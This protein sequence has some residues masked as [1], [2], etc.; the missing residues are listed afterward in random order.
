MWCSRWCS[1][2]E[3]GREGGIGIG[4]DSLVN[5]IDIRR[6][7]KEDELGKGDR[8]HYQ[9][10]MSS[11]NTNNT[12]QENKEAKTRKEGGLFLVINPFESTQLTPFHFLHFLDFLV[13]PHSRT[14]GC[15]WRCTPPSSPL[16]LKA[17]RAFGIVQ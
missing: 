9:E 14:S 4:Q 13:L 2:R 1:R 12:K 11:S 3:G 7:K 17:M 5:K 6:K 16:A 10:C 8:K 15:S